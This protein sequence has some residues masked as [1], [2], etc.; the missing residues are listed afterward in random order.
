MGDLF[1]SGVSEVRAVDARS[2]KELWYDPE[3][4]KS[5]ARRCAPPGAPAPRFWKGK[6]YLGTRDGRLIA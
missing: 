1:L 5:P 3:V 6:V 4:Y 2:G